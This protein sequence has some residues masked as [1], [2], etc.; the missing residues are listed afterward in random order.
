MANSD[1]AFELVEAGESARLAVIGREFFGN[2]GLAAYS[3]MVFNLLCAPCFAAMGA[4]RREMNNW[5]WTLFAIGYQC[6]FAY[7]IALI[8]NQFGSFF[9]GEGS[10]V[11]LAAAA[12][13]LAGLLFMMFRPVNR[14]AVKK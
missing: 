10:Y 3:F 2:S 5:K 14:K 6:G 8:I 11:G 13:V 12:L 1:L 9:S 4:I 7:C